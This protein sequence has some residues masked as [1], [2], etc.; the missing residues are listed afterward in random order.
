MQAFVVFVFWVLHQ[1]DHSDPAVYGW[2]T[3][4]GK[5]KMGNSI[6][7]FFE[8]AQFALALIAD[9]SHCPIGMKPTND[10]APAMARDRR[11]V[12]QHDYGMDVLRLLTHAAW[13]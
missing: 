5:V 9:T 10:A 3:T 4:A 8:S 2:I 6:R 11:L 7:R 1:F 13:A 12:G